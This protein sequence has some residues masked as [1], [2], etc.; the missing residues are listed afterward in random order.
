MSEKNWL[1]Y[2]KKHSNGEAYAIWYAHDC[3]GYTSNLLKAGHYT[4]EEAKNRCEGSHGDTFP[5]HIDDVC[6]AL[7]VVDNSKAYGMWCETNEERTSRRA[8][9]GR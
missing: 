4:E 3:N 6:N 7:I 8:S 5:I 2:S 1:I 9:N